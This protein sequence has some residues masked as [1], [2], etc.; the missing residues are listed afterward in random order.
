MPPRTNTHITETRIESEAVYDG[1]FLKVRRDT[2][3]LPDG[4]RATREYILHPGAVV[5]IAQPD[6]DHVIM[7]RQYRYPV[8]RVITEFP[9]GK[10]EPG[11]PPLLCARRELLEETGYSADEWRHAGDMHL[12]VGYS[13]EIIHIFFARGLTA[14]PPRLDHDE[15]LDV[16]IMKV[17][18][19]LQACRNGGITD[20]KSLS[21]ALWLQ[22]VRSGAWKL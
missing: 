6:D 18:D 8:Q 4:R 2:V 21:C 16:E 12:A 1:G 3:A 14:G 5:I 20:A 17:D 7:E 19:V 10:L 15:F 13:D 9:A 22:N 11:E